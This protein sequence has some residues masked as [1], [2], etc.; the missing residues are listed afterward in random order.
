MGTNFAVAPGEYLQEWI[1]GNGMSV[2]EFA[3]ELGVTVAEIEDLLTGKEAIGREIACQLE[4]VTSIPS[5]SWIRFELKYRE[6]LKRMSVGSEESC[7]SSI[8][9]E[10]A[11]LFR[12]G[13]R[14]WVE[15]YALMEHVSEAE[16]YRPKYNSFS[17]WLKGISMQIETV[18]KEGF[19]PVRVHPTDAGADLRADIPEPVTLQPR[20]STFFNT[21]I[22]V[23][24]PD[25]YFGALAIRSSLACKHGLMLANSLG[26][27]DSCYRGP[28]KAKLVN[29][30][31]RPYTI[32]PGDR[33]AQLLII[34]CV[35]AT[36]VQVDELPESD[37]GTGGFGSKGDQ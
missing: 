9:D 22:E 3:V 24:I 21:G 2:G 33:I 35:H 18:A 31:R 27:I 30:G 20:E 4:R 29:I 25:G 28:V 12:Q 6:D 1:D 23:A 11:S 14:S 19:L 26:I 10:L 34:P 8:H 15:V 32:N 37:R 5:D 36:F 7:T 13:G 16:L 17:A